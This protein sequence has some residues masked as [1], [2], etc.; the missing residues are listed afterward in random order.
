MGG[1]STASLADVVRESISE[2]FFE[3]LPDAPAPPSL[4]DDLA[5]EVLELEEVMTAAHHQDDTDETTEAAS[6]VTEE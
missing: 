6:D 3:T 2:R 4:G 5:R 1:D